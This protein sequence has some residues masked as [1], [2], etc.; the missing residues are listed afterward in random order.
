MAAVTARLAI[1]FSGFASEPDHAKHLIRRLFRFAGVE[2]AD[3]S[4]VPRRALPK[5]RESF[6]R[7]A[8]VIGQCD[9]VLGAFNKH[10]N[11]YDT[12]DA[13]AELSERL[14][15]AI[16]AALNFGPKESGELIH[17]AVSDDLAA[18]GHVGNSSLDACDVPVDPSER[19]PLGILWPGGPP[20]WWR[21][22]V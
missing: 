16:G 1:R 17:R 6:D 11:S 10:A 22:A 12:D 4:T 7:G 13:R 3:V 14:L 20:K 21:P 19:G 5:Y 8:Q 2:E 18:A 15:D 9:L